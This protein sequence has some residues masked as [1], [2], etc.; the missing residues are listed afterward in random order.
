M[1]NSKAPTADQTHPYPL[2]TLN[3]LDTIDTVT[4]IRLLSNLSGFA[5][6]WSVC[7]GHVV[8]RFGFA[9]PSCPAWYAW[10]LSLSGDASGSASPNGGSGKSSTLSHKVC[11]CNSSQ[12]AAYIAPRALASFKIWLTPALPPHIMLK[13]SAMHDSVTT[14]IPTQHK[15][16]ACCVL[17]GCVCNPG[18][19]MF[20]SITEP[21]PPP[22]HGACCPPPTHTHILHAKRS[23][24][25]A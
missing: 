23:L 25:A 5:V 19:G 14:S 20:R 24:G 7:V 2:N 18:C 8:R 1:V 15:R 3:T 11:K 21:F 22:A 10:V 17:R 16:A 12:H 4:G 6:P 9:L 13:I